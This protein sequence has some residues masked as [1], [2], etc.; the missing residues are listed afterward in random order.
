V[1]VAAGG[2][3]FASTLTAAQ[4]KESGKDV[5]TNVQA[6][7]YA[8]ALF[9]TGWKYS[10]SKHGEVYVVTRI[11]P[12][13]NTFVG[14]AYARSE[15][16]LGL[17]MQQGTRGIRTSAAVL[18]AL[19]PMEQTHNE[20]QLPAYR[21]S[22]FQVYGEFAFEQKLDRTWTVDVGARVSLQ[23]AAAL[24]PYSPSR[25]LQPGAFLG[26]RWAPLPTKL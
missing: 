17:R 20:F 5:G 13:L 25:I 2:A 3:A 11:A 24:N 19:A 1:E 15:S 7:P 18:Y 23:E 12:W 4:A 9:A 8:E 21:R 16:I 10:E 22:F 26:V 6:L 14:E